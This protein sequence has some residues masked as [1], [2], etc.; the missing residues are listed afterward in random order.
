MNECPCRV[1]EYRLEQMDD[2]LLLYHPG[3]TT[4]LYC[5]DTSALVWRLCD[6][7][8]SVDDIVKLL[9]EEYSDPQI[10]DDVRVTIEAL[11]RFGAIEFR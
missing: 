3:R 10:A 7:T 2:E 9:T 8:L 6:G 4:T 5:N 11:E 1:P